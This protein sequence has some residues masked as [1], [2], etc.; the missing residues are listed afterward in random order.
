MRGGE[1]ELA[2]VGLVAPGRLGPLEQRRPGERGEQLG[3][4]EV[5]AEV[6]RVEVGVDRQHPVERDEGHRHAVEHEAEPGEQRRAPRPRPDQQDREQGP[7]E[8]RHGGAAEEARRVEVEPRDARAGTRSAVRAHGKMWPRPT[9]TGTKRRQNSGTE[10]AAGTSV[11]A[12]AVPQRPP[13]RLWIIARTRPPT[14]D[15]A[16]EQ[17]ADQPAGEGGAR[18][19]EAA[20]NQQA[21][22]DQAGEEG[23]RGAAPHFRRSFASGASATVACCESW[24]ARM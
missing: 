21:A 17:E 19:P 10:A 23:Q 3:E 18:V 20:Q 4:G 13:V 12:I 7:A 14:G 24:S 11:A 9:P 22:R 2:Q 5:G 1:Q 15:A 8:E 16:P 6:G